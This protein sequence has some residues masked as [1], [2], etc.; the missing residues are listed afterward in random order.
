TGL[1]ITRE[2]AEIVREIDPTRPVTSALTE[3]HPEKNFIYQ[4]G[5]LDLLGFNYKHRDYAALPERFPGEKF[6]AAE[7]TS[8]LASRGHYDRPPDTP[9]HWPP[10]YRAPFDGNPDLTVSAYDRVSAFWGATHEETWK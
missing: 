7:T 8:G 1:S 10:A 9:V 5:A 4:S 3:N 2:L 6:I